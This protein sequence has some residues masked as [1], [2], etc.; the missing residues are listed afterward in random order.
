LDRILSPLKEYALNV[1]LPPK[2][3][4]IENIYGKILKK[5]KVKFNI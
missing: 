4:S 2:T 5:I 3:L 1:E